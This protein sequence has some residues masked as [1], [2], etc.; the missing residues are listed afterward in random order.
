MT[1][2]KKFKVSRGSKKMLG[3]REKTGKVIGFGDILALARAIYLLRKFD[4]IS[5][6]SIAI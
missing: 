1:E 6:R 2:M 3:I 5:L 4:I